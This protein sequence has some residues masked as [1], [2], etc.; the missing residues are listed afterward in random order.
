MDALNTNQ[1]IWFSAMWASGRKEIEQK[2]IKITIKHRKKLSEQRK[3]KEEWK[4]NSEKL[5]AIALQ[6]KTAPENLSSES[7]WQEMIGKKC[8]SE[9]H[10][11]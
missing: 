6:Y 4:K 9:S 11:D 7:L 8:I 5:T 1:F 10:I 3:R 2:K